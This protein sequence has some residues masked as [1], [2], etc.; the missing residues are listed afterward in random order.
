MKPVIQ[1]ETSGCGIAAVAN[2]LGKTYLEIKAIANA[3]GIYAE[4]QSLWSDTQYVR[5][6]LS[7]SGVET[8]ADEIPF[9]AWDKLPDL[10]LLAIKYH[11]E[12]G[13]NFWHWVVFKRDNGQAVVLDSASYLPWNTRNDFDA[14]QPKW[15][16]EVKNTSS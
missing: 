2:I 7:R 6:M 8:S 13:K 4:D 3:M 1:E 14:M 15:F 5:Q 16:I 12:N 10:A 9:E 11:Q